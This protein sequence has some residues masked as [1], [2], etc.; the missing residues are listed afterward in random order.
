MV[1]NHNKDKKFVLEYFYEI[2]LTFSCVNLTTYSKDDFF[3]D[4]LNCKII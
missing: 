4:I 2:D 3:S 1:S